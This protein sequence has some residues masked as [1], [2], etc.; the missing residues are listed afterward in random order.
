MAKQFATKIVLTGQCHDDGQL[1]LVAVRA[2]SAKPGR[3]SKAAGAES[4]HAVRLAGGDFKCLC[5]LALE[6]TGGTHFVSMPKMS[7]RRLRKALETVM[8][9]D[10]ARELIERGTGLRY[11]LNLPIKDILVDD[12]FAD[13]PS[14]A[15]EADVKEGIAQAYRQI[16]WQTLARRL[17]RRTG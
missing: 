16:P 12:A 13:L 7:I 6:R 10:A 8:S 14:D 2:A 4:W 3:A 11:R 9:R 15:V 1:V 17:G 5:R